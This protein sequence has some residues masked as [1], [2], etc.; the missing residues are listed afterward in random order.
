MSKLKIKE[1]LRD[2]LL[3]TKAIQFMW[4]VVYSTRQKAGTVNEFI[5]DL[6]TT[7]VPEK[8]FVFRNKSP[9]L[10]AANTPEHPAV[11]YPQ[12]RLLL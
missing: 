6:L 7:G 4:A 1:A 12:A 3:F 8:E 2:P 5:D 9:E 11:A 10:I